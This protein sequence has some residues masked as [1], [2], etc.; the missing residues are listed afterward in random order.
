MQKPRIIG[1]RI[2]GIRRMSNG[3]RVFAGFDAIVLALENG[4][5]IYASCDPEGNGPGVLF[6]DPKTGLSFALDVPID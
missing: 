3:E 5:I 6:C 4:T 2:V 1:Q